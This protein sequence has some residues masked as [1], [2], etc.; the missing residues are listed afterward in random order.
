[1]PTMR[2]MRPLSPTIVSASRA[3]M[4]CGGVA[5]ARMPAGVPHRADGAVGLVVDADLR[6]GAAEE[7]VGS[8]VV[9]R[10]VPGLRVASPSGRSCGG[11]EA[12]EVARA[13]DD[14]V[15]AEA[16][17]DEVVAAAALD[18][19]LA[20]GGRLERGD[21]DEHAGVVADASR[22]RR[23]R[24]RRA[25]GWRRRA[26]VTFASSDHA[27]RSSVDAAVALDDVVAE[28]AEDHVVG[29]RRRRGSRCRSCRRRRAGVDVERVPELGDV[30]TRPTTAPRR[31]RGT[32]ARCRRRA[33]GRC[34]PRSVPGIAAQASAGRCGC[35][36]ACRT[37]SGSGRSSSRRRAVEDDVVAED[38]VVGLVAVD[39][40]V[41]GAAD[42]HVATEAAE[43]RVVAAVLEV[44]AR[45]RRRIAR[46]RV[47]WIFWRRASGWFGSATSWMTAPWSPKTM[48]SYAHSGPPA[49]V[50]APSP[51]IRSLPATCSVVAHE[52]PCSGAIVVPLLM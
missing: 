25:C 42:E 14:V 2:M 29:L 20:V 45:D 24:S 31:G 33:A 23:R 38:H 8:A 5:S 41:A 30:D 34:C 10:Q 26:T 21:D 51:K 4:F 11:V 35:T 44:A 7:E 49:T 40:V 52:A 13:A 1:M 43:D 17:E 48:S 18:V 36:S 37:G 12:E 15:L 28:L 27:A 32:P 19:V 3:S 46:A 47:V 16:A 39:H 9:A 22:R 50:P 6:A